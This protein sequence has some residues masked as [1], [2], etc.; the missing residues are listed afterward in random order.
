MRTAI[1]KLCLVALVATA[2][3]ELN[4]AG[5]RLQ[6]DG[7]LQTGAELHEFEQ[8]GWRQFGFAF[9]RRAAQVGLT[10]R[11][12]DDAFGRV[13]FDLNS[14]SLRD[15][16][17]RFNLPSNVNLC[18]GL[19]AVPLSFDA[20]TPE[21]ELVV[22]GRSPM[23]WLAKPAGPRDVGIV[24]EWSGVQWMRAM[25]AVV[26]GSGAGATDDNSWKDFCARVVYGSVPG[27]GL[28]VAG[29]GYYGHEG[30]ASV[31][32]LTVGAEVRYRYEEL[33][34]Q[35]NYQRTI[36]GAEWMNI[37][38]AQLAYSWRFMVPAVRAAV[39]D[40]KDEDLELQVDAALGLRLIGDRV[41]FTISYQYHRVLND[42]FYGSYGIQLQ[43]S[44]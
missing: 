26:N 3:A 10:G 27:G 5:D 40:R 16:Y 19:L 18:A 24:A 43:G 30:S 21:R 39:I 32:W 38:D 6:L 1:A 7:L 42:W 4:L 37:A 17:L 35:G 14:L 11:I 31:A 9:Q 29:R 23:Y 15:L 28:E 8:G 2:Q 12:A 41:R 25:A 22:V 44:L 36:R 34:A 13:E 20:A 33:S